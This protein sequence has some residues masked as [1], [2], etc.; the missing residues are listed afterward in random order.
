MKPLAAFYTLS[1]LISWLIWLPLYGHRLGIGGLSTIPFNHA[2]GS[3]GP[4]ISNFI[5]TSIYYKGKRKDVV[6]HLTKIG[7]VKML[8]FALLAPLALSLFCLCLV[9]LIHK[10]PI[11]FEELNS[12]LEFSNWGY[13][14][15]L[16][17]NLFSF[18]YGEEVGWRGF[19]LPFLQQRFTATISSL[20]LT[21]FWAI[22]HL[23]LPA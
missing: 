18:G 23:P 11:R 14:P 21:I 22:W 15:F 8:L 7:S 12:N 19:A 10:T 5:I 9:A 13:M 16:L 6:S 4:L 3:W 17:Y 2:L 1:C 20:L